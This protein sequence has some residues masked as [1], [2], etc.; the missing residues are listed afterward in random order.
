MRYAMRFRF[1]LEIV[2][3]TITGVLFLITLVVRNWIEIVFHVSLDNNTGSLE[4]MIV[5]V[6]LVGTITFAVLARYEWRRAQTLMSTPGPGQT[7]LE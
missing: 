2:M 5:G 7:Q 1:W 4:W 6:L 3:A